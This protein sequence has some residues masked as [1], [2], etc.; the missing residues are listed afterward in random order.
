MGAKILSPTGEEEDVFCE[1]GKQSD[2]TDNESK[3]RSKTTSLSVTFNDTITVS[4]KKS[5][6]KIRSQSQREGNN[7]PGKITGKTKKHGLFS[8]KKEK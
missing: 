5:E 1:E 4:D 6:T 7:S 2:S 3:P 8:T